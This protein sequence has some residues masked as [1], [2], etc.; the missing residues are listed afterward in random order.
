MK[1]TE[2]IRQQIRALFASQNL[3]VL[4]TYGHGRPYAS[5]MAFAAAA[6]LKQLI[7]ATSRSTRKYANLVEVPKAAMLI[8]NR[9]NQVRDFGEAA[10][11]TAMGS[12]REI[13]EMELEPL[14]D[15]YL[16]KHSHLADFVSAPTCALLSMRVSCYYVV[17]RFQE[18]MELHI[19]Q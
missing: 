5:L 1:Q 3:G 8:D 17:N 10:A 18:V 19:T 12:V 13:H 11:V 14:V 2:E 9:S 16:S 4:A 6:D 15:L 7:F